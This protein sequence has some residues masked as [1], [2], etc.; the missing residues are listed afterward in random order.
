MERA[1]EK[2]SLQIPQAFIYFIIIIIIIIII[3]QSNSLNQKFQSRF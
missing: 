1:H 3:L 2:D